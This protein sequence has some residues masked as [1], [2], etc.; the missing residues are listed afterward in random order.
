MVQDFYT[1]H[2]QKGVRKQKPREIANY[3]WGEF[4]EAIDVYYKNKNGSS[5]KFKC[6]FDIYGWY[7]LFCGY[8][9]DDDLEKKCFDI[10]MNNKELSLDGKNLLTNI[11]LLNIFFDFDINYFL[12]LINY[13]PDLKHMLKSVIQKKS[14]TNNRFSKNKRKK[15]FF[16]AKLSP[17]QYSDLPL[18]FVDD[19]CDGL[20]FPVVVSLNGN[21]KV[22]QLDIDNFGDGHFITCDGEVM[23][24][25]RINDFW[26]VNENLG[27]RRKFLHRSINNEQLSLVCWNFTE[28]FNAAKLLGANSENGVI[29]R[30]LGG[31]L[32]DGRWFWWSSSS[33]YVAVKN[34]YGEPHVGGTQIRKSSFFNLKGDDLG[35]CGVNEEYLPKLVFFDKIDI[36]NFQKILKL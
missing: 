6:L 10:Y 26:L 9:T 25:I 2:K 33:R 3:K 14:F 20:L 16:K 4:N 28:M 1:T 11:Q 15:Q 27:L 29:V 36:K 19:F 13:Q 22:E 24:C 12:K 8:P 23:D 35:N 32:F 18:P 5:R 34:G 30:E 21:L 17:N 7:L 31:N